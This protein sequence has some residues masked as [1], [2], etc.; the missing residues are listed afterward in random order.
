ML[1]VLGKR[2][3]LFS[4]TPE[5]KFEKLYSRQQGNRSGTPVKET[6]I[7]SFHSTKKHRGIPT[8]QC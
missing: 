8:L 6:E 3:I 4:V 5:K 1:V 2:E 7:S